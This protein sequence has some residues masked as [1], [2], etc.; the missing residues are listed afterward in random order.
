MKTFREL[1]AVLGL[2]SAIFV[3]VFNYRDL[4]Q[5]I[6]THFGV[7]GVVDHW[8]DKS[9]LWLIVGLSCVLYAVLSLVRFLPTSLINVPVAQEQRAAAIPISFEMIAWLKA[10]VMCM[11]AFLTWT[12]VGVVEGRGQGL[13]VWFLPVTMV[14]IFGTIAFYLVRMLRL[15]GP[16][17]N[18]Q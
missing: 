3:V 8:G 9:A 2:L 14:V 7:S 4:P 13:G 16:Q 1:V 10:E 12:V 18:T 15:K 6:P 5:R 17:T 11:F